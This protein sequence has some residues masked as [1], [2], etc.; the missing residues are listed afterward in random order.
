MN[1]RIIALGSSICMTAALLVAT[2]TATAPHA[3]A[4]TNAPQ[5]FSYYVEVNNPTW[6]Y[7]QGCGLGNTAYVTAGTQRFTAILDFGAMTLSGSTWKLTEWGYPDITLAQAG[8]MVYQFGLGFYRCAS[9]DTTSVV[10]VGLGTNSS[11]N[12]SVAGA[13]AF[14]AQ[15]TS[16]NKRFASLI[17]GQVLV[18]GANDFEGAASPWASGITDWTWFDAYMAYA[19]RPYLFNYGSANGCPSDMTVKPVKASMCSYFSAEQIWHLSWAASAYPVPEIYRTDGINAK[20]WKWLSYYSY[21]LHG[22]SYFSYQ[23]VMTEYNACLQYPADCAIGKPGA[24]NNLPSVGWK[25]FNDEIHKSPAVGGSIL[26]NPT[27]ISWK[28]P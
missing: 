8:E 13:T 23:G 12:M 11:G 1:K 3:D 4:A 10:Y 22:G 17:Y 21:V 16:T 24:T 6:A 15:A 14:A 20:Q 27:D 18:V 2:Q 28:R 5:A 7:N 25:Q 9:S 26:N 19:G